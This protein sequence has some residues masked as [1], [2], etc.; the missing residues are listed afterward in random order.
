MFFNLKEK[1]FLMLIISLILKFNNN[2]PNLILS[3]KSNNIT[4][5][6]YLIFLFYYRFNT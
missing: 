4:D 5:N 6:Y 3:K 1:L 2:F